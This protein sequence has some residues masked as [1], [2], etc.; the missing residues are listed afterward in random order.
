MRKLF[1]AALVGAT[2]F[3]SCKKYEVSEAITKESIA[4]LPDK[5]IV[6]GWAYAQLDETLT[7]V[8]PVPDG[9]KVRVSIPYSQYGFS[10]SVT[11]NYIIDAV[12]KDGYYKIEV[13]VPSRSVT[14]TLSFEQIRCQVKRQ[15]ANGNPEQV[16]KVFTYPD[17]TLSG[18][19]GSKMNDVKVNVTYT[20]AAGNTEPNADKI[21]RPT[22]TR[23]VVGKLEY[24]D[25]DSSTN[26]Y[27][28]TDR[29]IAV[30]QGTKVIANITLT[31]VNNRT[32][33]EKVIVTVLAGGE[34]EL[35]VPMTVRGSA[36]VV[37]SSEGFWVLTTVTAGDNKKER[38]RYVLN[39]TFTVYDVDYSGKDFKYAKGA[40]IEDVE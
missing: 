7:G 11:G 24:M 14:C 5:V 15:D 37:L 16:W 9:T 29:Y 18:V 12:T 32:Y 3:T 30:P 34:Y 2:V 27:G 17:Q 25:R 10:T 23:K 28:S 38:Y 13:P 19:G 26:F 35:T 31:D 6:S 40:F 1:I 4:S 36:V 33:N 20:S 8:Q 39:Q 22:T 21:E